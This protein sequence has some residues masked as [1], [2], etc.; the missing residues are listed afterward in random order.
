MQGLTEFFPVSSSGHLVLAGELLGVGEP[1]LLFDVILHVA[2][3]SATVFY[4]RKE[5]VAMLADTWALVLREPA[6]RVATPPGDGAKW[7]ALVMVG[8]VPTAIAGVYFGPTFAE[9]FGRPHLVAG[10]LLVT[11]AMLI[12]TRFVQDVPATLGP[13]TLW[14]ALVVGLA[15]GLSIAPGLSRSGTTIAVALLIGVNRRAAVRL[16]FLLAIPAVV[17]ALLFELWRHP[18]SMGGM[19]TT[20]VALAFAVAAI[21]GFAALAGLVPLVERGR[22]HY[23]AVYLVPL[24]IWALVALP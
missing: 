10:L 18:L 24:A 13:P 22:L 9:L 14:Q 4:F 19:N 3:L 16:S 21:S 15:Q 12:V 2:T 7:L 6:E 17:G 1:E 5:L 20:V 11:A 8:S 23:F